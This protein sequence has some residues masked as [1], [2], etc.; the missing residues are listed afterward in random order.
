M[1]KINSLSFLIA[2]SA[3]VALA[4]AA[5]AAPA[6]L[7]ISAP[8]MLARTKVLA[9]DEFE[10]RAPGSPGEE[11]T[12]TYLAGEFKKMGLQPGN[13][14]GTYIQN[15]PMVGIVSKTTARFI[16]GG[17]DLG[18]QPI[19]DF[20]CPSS[21]VSPH[22]EVKDTGI[23]FVGY[24]VEAP[25]FGWDDYKGVDVR[26]KTV[27]MLINDPPVV[28]PA[29]GHLDPKIFGG[30]AMT[31]YGRWTYKYEMATAKGAAACLIIHETG[32]ASYP[33]AVVVGSRSRENFDL[34]TPDGNASRVAV[35]GWLTLD[36]A[37]KLFAAG[38]EDF[39][40]L[41]KAAAGRD[42]RPVELRA[43]VSFSVDNT[44]RNIA[45]RNV[46]AKL[47]G[48]D[49]AHQDEYMIYT[50]HWDHLGRDPKLTGD[51]IFN[52]ADDNASG[53]AQLLE[54]AQAYASLPASQR[55]R[56]SVLFLSVTGEEKGLIGSR[57]YAQNPLYPLTKTLANINIDGA[58]YHGRTKDVIVIGR[59]ASTLDDL[60]DAV[61]QTQNRTVKPDATPEKGRYYRSDHFEFAKVGV[62]ALYTKRGVDLIGKPDGWGTKFEA[63]FDLVDYHKV[64]DEVRPDWTFEGGAQDAELLF[65]VG[66][67]VA[68]TDVW[69]EWRAGNEFK[70]RR[71]EMMAGK[72]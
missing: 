56:R 11:K 66:R 23:V 67:R 20:V 47:P 65:E 17:K 46:V 2:A 59:G 19:N 35:E 7:D 70:A 54:I 5:P 27:V 21:R 63:D 57:Y 1:I 8:R 71:D 6:A 25:E 53:S 9:S 39:A 14:D 62:P 18:F 29:T 36:A 68:N 42:F 64:T 22:V 55:P 58:N 32:P 40:K 44:I 28:D 51:Q 30:G 72:H 13:P 38:G 37:Q 16:A 69:P 15:V 12:V 48:S 3:L 52:G 31:Y 50:A 33:F 45:S 41:K 34:L 24:G 60:V 49:A 43:R 26:G 10:G 4:P 61:A